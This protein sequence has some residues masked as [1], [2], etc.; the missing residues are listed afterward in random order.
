[1]QDDGV[2]IHDL[3]FY[4]EDDANREICIRVSLNT[5]SSWILVLQCLN[6]H[7]YLIVLWQCS[8]C[9]GAVSLSRYLSICSGVYSL[10]REA[11][12]VLV[13]LCSVIC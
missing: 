2:Y 5:F 8:Q 9:Q 6:L 12:C 3:D 1:M 11:R 13:V 7:Q 10:A 4:Y